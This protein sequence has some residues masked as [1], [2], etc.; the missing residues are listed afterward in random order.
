MAVTTIQNPP[1]DVLNTEPDYRVSHVFSIDDIT[2][3]FDGLTQGDVEAGELPVIDV[4]AAPKTTTEGVSLYPINSEF[5]FIVTDFDGAVEKDFYLNPEYTEGWAGDLHGEAGEQL[6]LVVS[7]AP[8]D[9]F[10]TPAK[11]GTWLAGLGGN[12]VKASTEHYAVMQ[13]VLSDQLFPGDPFAAYQ[14]DDNLMVVG[15]E[16]DGEYVADVLTYIDDENGDGEIDIRD[17]LAPNESTI[18]EAIAVS[19]DYSVTMKDDGKLL[20]RWGNEVKRPND[21]RLE[22]SLPLPDEWSEEDTESGLIPLYRVTAA[23][24]V[25]EHTITNNPNDQI[26]PEDLENESAIGQL[27]G[28]TVDARGRWVSEEGFYAGDGTFYP[29][30]TILRDPALASA[31][32]GSLLDRIGAMSSDLEGG[33]TNAYYTTMD[34]EPFMADLTDDGTDYEIGPRWRL[35]PDKYGQDLPG[36]VIPLDPRLTALPTRDEVRYEVGTDTTTVINLLDWENPVSP[37]SISIGYQNNSG[38]PSINGLNMTNDLDVAFYV[39]GDVKPATLYN[40]ELLMDYE[41]IEIFDAGDTVTGST[42]SDYLVGQGGNSFTG[43]AAD[44][45]FVVAYG[46]GEDLTGVAASTITDFAIGSDVVGLFDMGL[47]D[48]NFDH[49]LDQTVSGG[50]LVLSLGGSELVT[51][52]G[53]DSELGVESF[54]FLNRFVAADTTGTAGDDDLAGDA[55]DNVIEGLAGNDTI[56]GLDGDDTLYGG[57]GDDLLEGGLGDDVL[58]G[59]PGADMLM[60][61]LGFDTASYGSATAGVLVDLLGLVAAT[62]DAAGDTYDSIE[63]LEGSRFAD[64]FRGDDGGN[65]LFGGNSSDRLYGRAGDDT[66]DGGLGVDAIYGNLGVDVMS[67]G[68]AGQ[69]DRFI[70]FSELESRPH[71]GNRDIIT[72]FEPGIDRI[73]IGR[74]DADRTTP[75]SQDFTFIGNAP[76]SGAPGELRYVYSNGATVIQGEMDGDGWPDFEIE[77]SGILTLTVDDFL[78]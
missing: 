56:L 44:D 3:T 50:D 29:A 34:R 71:I 67:G 23:E 45:L 49:F 53:V 25:T 26:R 14:L 41:E 6:G 9:T 46:A 74:I 22:V 16:H 40:T 54:L 37:L 57:L 38:A 32:E 65:T 60:G 59:G 5:G 4:S 72:D 30:G 42:G 33:F 17:I 8:T 36:V 2:G 68:S 24:L 77:L 63:A 31:A 48:L 20:Y 21:I 66:I 76:F 15:G 52:E 1:D 73:E 69:T 75:L 64:N 27:P 18:T 58:D 61:G 70:Y 19:D 62:N 39:K 13:H 47:T 43:G 10:Q 28:Y 7:N 55:G 11:L 12:S 35:Q 78:L 51:L